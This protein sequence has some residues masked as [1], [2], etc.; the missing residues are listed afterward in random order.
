MYS[1][2]FRRIEEF[3]YCMTE[4]VNF[5]PVCK[6]R[7][8][9]ISKNI[10]YQRLSHRSP[11]QTVSAFSDFFIFQKSDFFIISVFFKKSKTYWRGKQRGWTKILKIIYIWNFLGYSKVQRV[12]R[13][14]FQTFSNSALVINSLSSSFQFQTVHC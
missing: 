14:F 10:F 13:V 2:N 12:A 6:T 4:M 7:V 9:K 1:T 3:S 5:S 11:F 8:S